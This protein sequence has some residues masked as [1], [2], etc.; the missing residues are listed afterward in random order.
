MDPET[1]IQKRT[2]AETCSQLDQSFV[3]FEWYVSSCLYK[4]YAVQA[5]ELFG[6]IK[7]FKSIYKVESYSRV[8]GG[9]APERIR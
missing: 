4:L 3:L 6:R 2:V 1:K 7:L 9:S 8:T 5:C